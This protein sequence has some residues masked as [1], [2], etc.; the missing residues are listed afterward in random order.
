MQGKNGVGKTSLVE[1]L[2]LFAPGRGL[3]NAEMTHFQRQQSVDTPWSIGLHIES[4]WG[5]LSFETKIV[6]N[7]RKIWKNQDPLRTHD[8]IGQWIKMIWPLASMHNGLSQR[9]FCLNRLVFMVDASY[10]KNLLLYDRALKERNCLLKNQEKDR[11]W[12]VS[13][14]KTLAFQAYEIVHK[15]QS[16]LHRLMQEMDAHTTPFAKPDLSVNG[17]VE[18]LRKQDDFIAC[19]LKRLEDCRTYDYIRGQTSFGVH[20]T[21]FMMTHPN[22]RDVAVCSSGEKNSLLLSVALSALRISQRDCPDTHHFLIADEAMAYL[23]Q[24]KQDW[25]WQEM[26]NLD[27]CVCVTGLPDLKVPCHIQKMMIDD[28]TV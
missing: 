18:K 23:D 20:K 1:A 7:R 3:R 10:G 8:Q 16:A 21:H 24:E 6:N 19:Y 25:L 17:E 13:L 27:A 28:Q 22:G 9:R 2:S 26:M 15:R 14:E 4:D 11:Q 5:P 12:F